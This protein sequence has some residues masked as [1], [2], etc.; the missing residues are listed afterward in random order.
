[1]QS[2]GGSVKTVITLQGLQGNLPDAMKAV[3]LNTIQKWEHQMYY[4]G[5]LS[6][7]DAQFK[8]KAYSSRKY[9]SHQRAPE[10]QLD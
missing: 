5:G 10:S 2:N 8:V 7:H 9:T 1:V 4:R 3:G 6:A